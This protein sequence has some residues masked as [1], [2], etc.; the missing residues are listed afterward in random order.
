MPGR[1]KVGPR[2]RPNPRWDVADVEVETVV[3]S[4]ST[5]VDGC[6]R[7]AIDI[8]LQPEQNKLSSPVLKRGAGGVAARQICQHCVG[9]A[10]LVSSE[11]RRSTVR[12][13][14]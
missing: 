3:V 2:H 10:A 5:G 12:C 4:V 8:Y 11:R 7:P 9:A 14:T 1:H 6:H 13:P